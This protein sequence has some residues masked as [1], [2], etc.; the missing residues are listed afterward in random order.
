MKL[1]DL[2]REQTLQYYDNELKNM[3][4]EEARSFIK[5][6]YEELFYDNYEMW[7]KVLNNVNQQIVLWNNNY[8]LNET[9]EPYQFSFDEF[10][11]L[12]LDSAYMVYSYTNSAFSEQSVGSI[13]L[14]VLK[15]KIPNIDTILAV[16][17]APSMYVG[18]A[19]TFITE[20][21]SQGPTVKI[22]NKDL[23]QEELDKKSFRSNINWDEWIDDENMLYVKEDFSDYN[24][25]SAQDIDDWSD[26]FV[27]STNDG[28]DGD[29]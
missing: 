15:I 4:P 18:E 5:K 7:K 10:C 9:N 2:A 1:D 3:E 13:I 6:T 28:D 22:Y 8:V 12:F 26:R 27:D 25:S 17:S 21:K 14:N 20:V 16:Q 19:D 29:D 11:I 24:E 23:T